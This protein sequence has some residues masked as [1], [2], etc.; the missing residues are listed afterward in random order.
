M[1]KKSYDNSKEVRDELIRALRLDLFGPEP[2]RDEDADFVA[3]VLPAEPSRWY[4]GGFLVPSRDPQAQATPLSPPR[5]RR[6]DLLR[7]VSTAVG[8][9]ES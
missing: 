2:G 7:V 6:M 9:S 4:L 5:V 3:E 1:S 8:A